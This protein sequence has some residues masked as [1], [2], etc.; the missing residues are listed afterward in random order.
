MQIYINIYKYIC[1]CGGVGGGVCV[2]FYYGQI[3][4]KAYSHVLFLK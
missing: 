3:D 1:V 4:F 2:S